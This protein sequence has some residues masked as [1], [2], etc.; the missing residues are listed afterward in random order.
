MDVADFLE[1][2]G[3][4]DLILEELSLGEH[5]FYDKKTR[6]SLITEVIVIRILQIQCNL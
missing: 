5:L 1:L 3:I 6:V 4:I 2:L